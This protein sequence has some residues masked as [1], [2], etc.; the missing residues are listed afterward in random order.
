MGR[1]V[2]NTLN[3]RVLNFIIKSFVKQPGELRRTFV[4][5]FLPNRYGWWWPTKPSSAKMGKKTIGES[6]PLA[7]ERGTREKG[8][9]YKPSIMHETDV[10]P[11]RS[12]SFFAFSRAFFFPLLFRRP[13]LWRFIPASVSLVT[14]YMLFSLLLRLGSRVYTVA[15]PATYRHHYH[16]DPSMCPRAKFCELAGSMDGSAF[17]SAAA[18]IPVCHD[19]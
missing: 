1:S 7:K 13:L 9:S 3:L 4:Y 12:S 15:A 17:G 2:K 19:R 18:S 14:F 16:R 11:P 10:S 5:A 6:S 8:G